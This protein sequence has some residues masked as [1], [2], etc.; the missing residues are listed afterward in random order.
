MRFVLPPFL[1]HATTSLRS[2]FAREV[3]QRLK[4][5][6]VHDLLTAADLSHL[7]GGVQ[8]YIEAS[9]AVG[10]ERVVNFRAKFRGSIRRNPRAGWMRFEAEQYNFYPDPARLFLIESTLFGIPFGA[11]HRYVGSSATMQADVAS[12]LRVVDAHG[13]EMTRSETV[14]MFNDMCAFAPATLI[15]P[16]LRFQEL[17]PQRVRGTFSNAG[18]TVSAELY[19]NERWQLVN[20]VSDDRSQTSDGKTYDRYRWS[21]PLQD[22]RDFGGRRVAAQGEASWSMPEGEFA[23]V[24]L[25]LLSLEYNAHGVETSKEATFTEPPSASVAKLKIPNR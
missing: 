14:T 9:G 24:R 18:Y 17:G 4:P 16:K 3:E 5:P 25:E 12:V 11:F 13:P 6:A 19:F 8:R 10:R 7:P 23:Y 2:S 20:F 1:G 22:Y 15:D 21:T